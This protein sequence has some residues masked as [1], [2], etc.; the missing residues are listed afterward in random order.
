ML[1]RAEPSVNNLLSHLINY[2]N[3]LLNRRINWQLDRADKHAILA[4]TDL[5]SYTF[6]R[7]VSEG[8]A[9]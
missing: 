8:I 6:S 1:I 9:W 5:I 7:Q 3:R 4:I 2:L